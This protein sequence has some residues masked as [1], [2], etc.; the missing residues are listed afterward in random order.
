MIKLN[1]VVSTTTRDKRTTET[2]GKDY[3][4]VDANTF[5]SKEIIGRV[6]YDGVKPKL[7]GV[8][9]DQILND[10]INITVVNTYGA[11]KLKE[12][13]SDRKVYCVLLH[14]DYDVIKQRY[15]SRND[16]DSN[17]TEFND[18]IAKD[19]NDFDIEFDYDFICN[20]N[21]ELVDN[22]D[23]K[24]LY[25]EVLNLNKGDIVCI[26]GKTGVG[27]TSIVNYI[28]NENVIDVFNLHFIDHCNYKCKHCFAFKDNVEMN[29]DDICLSVDKIKEYFDS[30]G[31]KGRINL[32]GGEILLSKNIQK[33]ID[34][35]NSKD[36]KVSIVTNGSLLTEEFIEKNKDVIETIGISV[37]SIVDDVNKSIGRINEKVLTKT[38]ILNLCNLVNKYDIRLKINICLMTINCNEDFSELLDNINLNRLKIFQMKIVKG[39]N[40]QTSNLVIDDETFTN[41]IKKFMKYNPVIEYS[42]EIDKSY[43]IINSKGEV[44]C[45]AF[46]GVLGSIY[47]DNLRVILNSEKIDYKNF[48]KRYKGENI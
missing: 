8:G 44:L 35:I 33:I 30:Y 42:S 25:L 41:C 46:D 11:S 19:N 22:E 5:M 7:Y 20:T 37:D 26:M 21:V 1:R 18:R 6:L 2:N 17:I 45:N 24:K 15:L 13:Y 40:D 3:H 39:I 48:N 36:I 28:L 38:E 16:V 31:V 14:T 23:A 29:F 9:S 32:V 10:S 43:L 27:K 47:N 34:Y 12:R 4:Y